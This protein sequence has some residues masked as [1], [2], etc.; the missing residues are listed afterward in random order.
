MDTYSVKEIADMLNT[1]PETV[2]RQIRS[3]KLE[4]IQESRKGG[5]VLTKAM[6]K[7]FLKNSPKYVGIVTGL[8]ASPVG[9]T[10]ATAAIVG[11]I[12]AQ[13]LINNY[14]IKNAYV[15]ISEIRKLLL[16]NIQSSKE[17]IA[18]KK[19]SIKYFQEEIVEEQLRITE[20]EKLIK[21]LDEK[22]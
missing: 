18:I 9:L 21:G 12:L 5:N 15:N 11:G 13:Q 1:N 7:V 17:N 14:K 6:L 16:F 2:R 8:L 4:A 22:I 20:A 19:K 10:T 3:G